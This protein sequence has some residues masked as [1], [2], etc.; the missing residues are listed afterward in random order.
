[1][2]EQEQPQLDSRWQKEYIGNTLTNST[3]TTYGGPVRQLA[4]E[5]LFRCKDVVENTAARLKGWGALHEHVDTQLVLFQ[6]CAGRLEGME[7]G[8]A[9]ARLTGSLHQ[10]IV[11]RK[12]SVAEKERRQVASCA[13]MTAELR[14]GD[15]GTGSASLMDLDNV[16]NGGFLLGLEQLAAD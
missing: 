10:I 2:I 7:V 6:E 16:L 1:M 4:A 15:G 13:A 5:M 14:W 9:S 12:R 11:G 8:A 3:S